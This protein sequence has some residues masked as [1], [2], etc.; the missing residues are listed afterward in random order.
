MWQPK[1]GML[2]FEVIHKY[3]AWNREAIPEIYENITMFYVTYVSVHLSLLMESMWT[4]S[5][6]VYRQEKCAKRNIFTVRGN[7]VFL[8]LRF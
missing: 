3:N 8:H 2:I 7:F 4:W 6:L 5:I 1:F